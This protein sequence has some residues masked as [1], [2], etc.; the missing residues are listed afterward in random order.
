MLDLAVR[1]S[2]QA[3]ASCAAQALSLE[4]VRSLHSE[5]VLAPKP[6]LVCPNDNGSHRDMTATTLFRSLFALRHYFREI[7]EAAWHG[8]PF[9]TLQRLGIAAEACMLRATQGVNTHRG[10]IFNLGLLSAAAADLMARGAPVEAVGLGETVRRRWGQAILD[11]SPQAPSHGLMV[12]VRYGAGGAR[13]EAASGF[14]TVLQTGLP[15]LREALRSGAGPGHA[16]T[17]TLF[18]LIVDVEDTNLLYR[19]GR[20]GLRFAQRTAR[21]FLAAG[22]V[23]APGWRARAQAIRDAFVARNL[24]PGGTA[25]LL[26]A[27]WFVH[28]IT[29]DR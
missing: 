4:A 21:D 27:T 29:A 9:A 23:H 13:L 7:A 20:D 24:S 22:G 5:L 2:A 1:E 16:L 17:Q 8:A 26:A 25:D 18:G 6:G 3:H 12:A 28:R 15:L 11:M 14:P 19:G 10:A